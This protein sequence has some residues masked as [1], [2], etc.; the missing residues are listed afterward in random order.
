MRARQ[1]PQSPPGRVFDYSVMA[2]GAAWAIGSALWLVT[3]GSSVPW[4]M[5]FAAPVVALIARYPMTLFARTAS[6]QVAFDFCVI[7]FLGVLLS[8]SA[9]MTVYSVGIVMSLA[10]VRVRWSARVFNVGLALVSGG[11]GLWIITALRG[12]ATEASPLELVAVGLGCGVAFLVDYLLSEVSVA[13]EEGVEVK[14]QLFTADMAVALTTVVAV[15]SVGYLGA[16]V[17][18]TLPLWSLLLLAVPLVALVAAGVTRDRNIEMNRRMQV[19]FS[20]ATTIH[21]AED[22]EA[23]RRAVES[24]LRALA[25]GSSAVDLRRRPPGD[26]EVGARLDIDQ[27]RW[28]LVTGGLWRGHR[29]PAADRQHLASLARIGAEA[30]TRLYMQETVTRLAER[31]PLTG[32]HNRAVFLRQADEALARCRGTGRRVGVLFCD[33]DGFKT[34]NDWF[35]HAA[36]DQLL[37]DVTR[38]L[39]QTLGSRAM[40]ARLGGDEFA[41]LIQDLSVDVDLSP[42]SAAVLGAVERR[43]ESQGRFAMV[44][45]SLGWACSDGRHTAEQLLRNADIAMYEAKSAGKNCA[46]EYHPALGRSRVRALALAEALSNAVESRDLSVVYQPVVSAVSGRVT[47][48]EALARWEHEGRQVPPDVFIPLAEN[49]GLI[50]PLGEVVLDCVAA[51][52]ARLSAVVDWPLVIGVNVSA[53]QLPSPSFVS[54]VRRTLRTTRPL[55]LNLEI[56]ERQVVGDDVA[57]GRALEALHADGVRLSLDDFGVGFSSIGYLQRLAVSALKIDRKFCVDIDTDDRQRALL[58]SMISMGE[59][60]GLDV[61]IEGVERQAQLDVLL[62]ELGDFVEHVYVQGNLMGVPMVLDDIVAALVAGKSATGWQSPERPE[63]PQPASRRAAR[64]ARAV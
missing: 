28:W 55:E 23:V 25:R 57:V 60:M 49:R 14:T 62:P 11:T 6:V 53:L 4:G 8:Q 36:G 44:S 17:H 38:S 48:L 50:E 9:A 29:S 54:A 45:T 7:A 31:D 32:L 27:T 20:A 40:V 16:I 63:L 41:A 5:W 58:H 19:L 22:T 30:L 47:G 59:A 43:F 12:S 26:K 2:A 56:T 21:S 3:T 33:L 61:V 52:A 64:A 46:R 15:A 24:G 51:D 39:E 18:R 42:I 37:I 10:T 34:V 35:G 13:L 1:A